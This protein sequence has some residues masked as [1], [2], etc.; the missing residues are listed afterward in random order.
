MYSPKLTKNQFQPD[1][2]VNAYVRI[3]EAHNL[4]YSDLNELY[5]AAL[6][7][8]FPRITEI[9]CYVKTIELNSFS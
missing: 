4:D 9:E 2:T 3:F 6:M 1:F 8:L 5:D 7:A